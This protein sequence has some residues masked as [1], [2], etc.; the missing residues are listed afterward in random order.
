MA[1]KLKLRKGILLLADPFMADPGFKRA[2]ILLCDY[3][4][5]GS[6]G[7]VLNKPLNVPVESLLSDFPEFDSPAYYGGPVGNDTLHYIHNVGHLLDESMSIGEGLYWGGDFAQLKVLIKQGLI[8][9]DSI[10]FFVGYSGWSA[11]QLEEEIST[12]TWVQ[13]PFNLKYIFGN[14]PGDLWYVAMKKLGSTFEILSDMSDQTI[15]N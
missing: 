2:A 7:F 1:K 6:V 8:Q 10:Q 5:E 11:G 3:G 15:W 4:P 9:Q 14:Q 12:N 13:A